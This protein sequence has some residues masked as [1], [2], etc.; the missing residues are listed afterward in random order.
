MLKRQSQKF[1]IILLSA[2][3][4]FLLS[5]NNSEAMYG[6]KAQLT[7]PNGTKM[8]TSTMYGQSGIDIN[9][10]GNIT[11]KGKTY[12]T[13][14]LGRRVNY[15]TARLYDPKGTLIDSVSNSRGQDSAV[16]SKRK[17]VKKAVVYTVKSSHMVESI[18]ER[19]DNVNYRG[20]SSFT[21]RVN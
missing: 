1:G 21:R 3:F 5:P 6:T 14:S 20:N 18:Y 9:S 8:S 16:A 12:S 19:G 10:S 11:F 13:S 15:V 7:N 4:L 2:S 17:N